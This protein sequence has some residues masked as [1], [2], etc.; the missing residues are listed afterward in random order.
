MINCY[1]IVRFKGGKIMNSELK[2]MLLDLKNSSKKIKEANERIEQTTKE[3]EVL[4]EIERKKQE[5]KEKMKQALIRKKT[6]AVAMSIVTLVNN[7]LMFAEETKGRIKS[8]DENL[9]KIT[10]ENEDI[11][12]TEHSYYMFSEDSLIIY[13]NYSEESYDMTSWGGK[14]IDTNSIDWDYLESILTE[15]N[16]EISRQV[17]VKYTGGSVVDLDIVTIEYKKQPEKKLEL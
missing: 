2:N 6:E 7:T 16:I 5:R 15:A 11:E 4:R 9:G 12:D 8:V 14:F 3:R 13:L 10:A 1:N 17:E